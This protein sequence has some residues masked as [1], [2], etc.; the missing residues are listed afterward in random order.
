M[1]L[2]RIQPIQATSNALQLATALELDHRFQ[3]LRVDMF[4]RLVG[5]HVLAAENLADTNDA[6]REAA[7]EEA[8][9]TDEPRRFLSASDHEIS[10]LVREALDI[11]D[12]TEAT[13]IDA[14]AAHY[15]LHAPTHRLE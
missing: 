7:G 3:D 8:G 4:G 9:D 5:A 6:A 13:L 12:T 10:S 14:E 1:Q 11:A 15:D 2:I